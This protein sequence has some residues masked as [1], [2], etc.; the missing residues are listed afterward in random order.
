MFTAESGRAPLM[1]VAIREAKQWAGAN[2]K[3]IEDNYHVLSDS[4]RASLSTAW[5]ASFVNYCLK[6]SGSQYERSASSQF[7]ISSRRFE[8]IKKPVYGALVVFKNYRTDNGKAHGTGHV[9]F[10]F[11]FNKQG[12]IVALGGNQGNTIKFSP[13]KTHGDS[14]A[15]NVGTKNFPIWV[16]QRFHEYYVPSA[17]YSFATN[18]ELTG[19]TVDEAELNKLLLGIK[20]NGRPSGESTR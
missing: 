17:Y 2:E 20:I 1:V 6:D 18:D 9:T 5:C 4:L 14:A 15:F 8:R 13:Y 19:E 3:K 7:P 10:L 11:G 12:H 16:T